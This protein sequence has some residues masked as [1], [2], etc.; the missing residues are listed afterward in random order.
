MCCIVIHCNSYLN[1]NLANQPMPL[2]IGIL[3]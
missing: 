1:E 2:A 3:V